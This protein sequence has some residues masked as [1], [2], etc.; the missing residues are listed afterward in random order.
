M[1]LVALRFERLLNHNARLLSWLLV[2]SIQ[3][4]EA[5]IAPSTARSM[6][7]CRRSGNAP[8]ANVPDEA[9][10]RFVKIFFVAD[11][12]KSK[13]TRECDLSQVNFIDK[14]VRRRRQSAREL[15]VSYRGFHMLC[16]K[17]FTRT[18]SGRNTRSWAFHGS[19]KVQQGLCKGAAHGNRELRAKHTC[20][21]MRA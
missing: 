11:Y 12:I 10:C 2:S 6:F 4:R 20:D 1:A 15:T 3:W 5:E 7:R 18:R 14:R 9:S 13:M 16:A 8:R 17:N 19:L 21:A